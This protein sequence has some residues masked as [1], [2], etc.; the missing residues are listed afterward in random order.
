MKNTFKKIAASVMAVASLAVGMTGISA[1]AYGGSK[2]FTVYTFTATASIDRTTTGGSA[3]TNCTGS[4]INYVYARVTVTSSNGSTLT[5][6]NDRKTPG[7][8]TASKNISSCNDASSYHVARTVT[9][10]EGNT[11][12]RA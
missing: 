10:T 5:D 9:G 11:S 3:T 6:N 1:S 4:T 2:T 8:I 12:M 7:S